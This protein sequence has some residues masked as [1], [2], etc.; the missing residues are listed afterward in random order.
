MKHLDHHLDDFEV[1]SSVKRFDM[2]HYHLSVRF[3]LLDKDGEISE[4]SIDIDH[5]LSGRKCSQRNVR[6][7]VQLLP[8][9]SNTATTRSKLWSWSKDPLVESVLPQA[10][11]S[12]TDSQQ[13]LK[14]FDSLVGGT[15]NDTA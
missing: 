12:Q 9:M 15:L 4:P 13:W 7:L 10:T 11:I 2:E 14:L 8:A 1:H 3:D 6:T 5:L